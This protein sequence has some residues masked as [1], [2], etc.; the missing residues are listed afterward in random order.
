NARAV[1]D[2]YLAFTGARETDLWL[3]LGDN[4]YGAGFDHE[5]QNAVFDMFPALLRRTVLWSTIGNHETYGGSLADFPY[6]HIFTLPKEGQAGGVPSGT[7]RYYSFDYGNIHFVCLDAMT[8]LRSSDGP[9][10]T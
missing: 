5:Y 6:L 4:A 1:Y 9:M 10:A 3:M 7:E 8:S 2:A